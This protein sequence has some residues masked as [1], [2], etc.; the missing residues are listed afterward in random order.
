MT[1]SVS[2]FSTWNSYRIQKVSKMR[3]FVVEWFVQW[4]SE[5]DV[6]SWIRRWEMHLKCT[7]C[8]EHPQ[9]Y[10]FTA[11]QFLPIATGTLALINSDMSREIVRFLRPDRYGN[12]I[13]KFFI[14]FFSSSCVVAKQKKRLEK[15]LHFSF[16]SS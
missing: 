1:I 11:A 9:S 3:N 8:T 15:K 4:P 7:M 16:R 13:H 2:A 14:L 10:R 5:T 6:S 12:Q